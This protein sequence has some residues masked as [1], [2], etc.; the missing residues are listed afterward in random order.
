MQKKLNGGLYEGERA[1]YNI[2]NVSLENVTFDNGESPLKECSNLELNGCIFKWK[3]PLWYCNN[4][5]VNETTFIDLARSGIWYTNNITI[6]KSL[7]AVP[8][9]FRRCKGVYLNNV[10]IPNA[11]ETL[12]NCD[13]IVLN[14]VNAKGDYFAMNSK[15]IKIKNFNL[16]GNYAFDGGENIEI[17]NAVMNSKDS[18][19]NCNN[20]VVYDS[21][22]IGEYL[23]WNSKNL[24]FVN[25]TIDSEQGMCYIDNI[26]MINCKLLNTNL[27]FERCND[28]NAEI[29]TKIDSVKNPYSGKIKALKIDEIILDA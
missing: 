27:A 16:D 5:V 24:K 15:N 6:N 20:V 1:L 18:F 17:R 29:K 4:V 26:E 28:I 12:W 3:Y 23:G 13:D 9:Q 14:D 11:Q 8:K 19:W 25:C 10:N 7:I 22:I 2:H 21:I